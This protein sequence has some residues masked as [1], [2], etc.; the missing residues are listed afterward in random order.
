L[1]KEHV[2]VPGVPTQGVS[3]KQL[4]RGNTQKIA[5]QKI[6]WAKKGNCRLGKPKGVSNKE[7]LGFLGEINQRKPVKRLKKAVNN[8]NSGEA[9]GLE[10]PKR[11]K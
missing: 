2:W 7:T 8:P 6:G 11:V 4:K 1:G 10:P 3:Q 5:G 9:K